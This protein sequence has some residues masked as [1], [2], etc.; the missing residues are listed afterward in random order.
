M[1]EWATIGSMCAV[2]IGDESGS[3]RDADLLDELAFIVK[4]GDLS[5]PFVDIDAQVVISALHV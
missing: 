3:S 4:D 1:D 2:E 5:F